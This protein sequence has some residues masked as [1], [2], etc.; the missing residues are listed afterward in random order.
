MP[1][2]RLRCAMTTAAPSLAQHC[3]MPQPM[4]VPP[5]VIM[6]TLSSKRPLI[7][8]S[9]SPSSARQLIDLQDLAG[10]NQWQVHMIGH[11]L[12]GFA[13]LEADAGQHGD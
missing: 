1:I 11:T 10:L 5:P 12:N 6:T 2:S 4:P 7:F 8:V 3:V 9:G 13:V